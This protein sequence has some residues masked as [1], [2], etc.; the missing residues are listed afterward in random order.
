[1]PNLFFKKRDG[2]RQY[3]ILRKND[4]KVY[5]CLVAC[6]HCGKE[7]I[8]VTSEIKRSKN[9]FCSK[10]CLSKF[11]LSKPSKSKIEVTC[12]VCS[13]K[14]LRTPSKIS[15]RKFFFCSKTCQAKANSVDGLGYRTGP[16]QSPLSTTNSRHSSK[17]LYCQYCG[18]E[19]LSKRMKKFCTRKCQED[20]RYSDLVHLW[21]SGLHPGN[22]PT[23]LGICN[24]V[25]RYF[26]EKFDSSCQKCGWSEV[27]Q[28]TGKIPLTLHHIN[29]DSS[30]NSEKNLELLCPNCHSL[31]SNYCSLNKN[32]KR[33][34]KR[35][36]WHRNKT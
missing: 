22:K 16:I 11:R 5:G 29:G 1:M 35:K 14:M 23:T 25:R 32:S 13:K 21:K 20:K 33:I 3:Y 12:M 2:T 10:E 4:R 24:F 30:D 17:P 18:K 27:N 7:F 6:D 31:T 28:T 34:T 26:F 36:S 9:H 15:G 8:R 19:I